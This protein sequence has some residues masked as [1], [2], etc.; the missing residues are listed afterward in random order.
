M[1]YMCFEATAADALAEQRPS[2]RLQSTS[3]FVSLTPLEWSVVALAR[4]DRLST[5]RTPGRLS[6]ITDALFGRHQNPCLADP[7]LE[8]LRRVAVLV[9]HHGSL[10]HDA[11]YEGFIAMGFTHAHYRLIVGGIAGGH[12]PVV[13]KN[14][15]MSGP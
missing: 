13:A 11:E 1:A 6:T 7:R 8:V 5:L 2:P 9:W 15:E 4:G 12:A 3:P 14:R 10:L